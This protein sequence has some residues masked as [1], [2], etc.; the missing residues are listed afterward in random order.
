MILCDYASKSGSVLVFEGDAAMNV[1]N[2]FAHHAPMP[3]QKRHMNSLRNFARRFAREIQSSTPA[4]RNQTLAIRHV[5]DAL[6]RANKAIF[7]DAQDTAEQ[8]WTAYFDLEDS[9][10][11][12]LQ[13]GVLF[14][15]ETGGTYTPVGRVRK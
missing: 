13:D 7:A 8:S 6:M 5:E 12:I 9:G 4:G 14:R 1:D 11:Y 10:S 15:E 2:M 3:A